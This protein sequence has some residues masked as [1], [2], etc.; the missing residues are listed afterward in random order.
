MISL[1]TPPPQVHTKTSTQIYICC[2]FIADTL[3]PSNVL[4]LVYSL[5]VVFF[6][7]E[8][9]RL[10]R[11]LLLQVNYFFLDFSPRKAM[12]KLF[13][14]ESVLCFLVIVLLLLLILSN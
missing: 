11:L 5:V 14:Q 10:C 9:L 4:T 13:R 3:P 6:F 1:M 2:P 7:F 12:Y 8:V